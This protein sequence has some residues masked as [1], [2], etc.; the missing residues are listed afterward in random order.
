MMLI[1]DNKAIVEYVNKKDFEEEM[2]DED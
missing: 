1:G 2:K